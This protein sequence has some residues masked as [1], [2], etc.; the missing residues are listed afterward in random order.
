MSG[1]AGNALVQ[2]SP[3]QSNVHKPLIG[4]SIILTTAYIAIRI[5]F[6]FKVQRARSILL[7]KCGSLL[8][9]R[10]LRLVCL[11]HDLPA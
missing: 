7:P 1:F 10:R 8:A 4:H 5:I 6:V 2:S 9:A 11:S 3:R